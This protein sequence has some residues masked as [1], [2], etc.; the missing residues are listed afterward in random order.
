MQMFG[1]GIGPKVALNIERHDVAF[2]I[3]MDGQAARRDA[4]FEDLDGFGHFFLQPREIRG[5][6]PAELARAEIYDGAVG[7]RVVLKVKGLEAFDAKV[8][9]RIKKPF[10]VTHH[11]AA[12]FLERDDPLH[13]AFF[14][15]AR[16]I[17]G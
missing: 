1:Q 17:I 6:Q 9:M 7:I 14:A 2:E 11:S 3:G 4:G 10:Q 12:I 15:R 16:F 8:G 13:S 5:R